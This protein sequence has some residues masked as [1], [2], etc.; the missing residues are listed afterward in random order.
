MFKKS[1]YSFEIAAGRDGM[2]HVLIQDTDEDTDAPPQG[3]YLKMTA[4]TASELALRMKTAAAILSM[5]AERNEDVVQMMA[6]V[7]AQSAAPG[8]STGTDDVH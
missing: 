4:K 5:A 2:V 1:R 6:D 8:S 3:L 7:A